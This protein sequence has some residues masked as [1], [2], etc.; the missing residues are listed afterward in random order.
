[1]KFLTACV[2]V[3]LLGKDSQAQTSH[4]SFLLLDAQ[5]LFVP[6]SP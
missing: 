6:T 4:K 1:M 2:I 5:Y 3:L